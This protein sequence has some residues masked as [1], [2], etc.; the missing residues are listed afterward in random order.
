MMDLQTIFGKEVRV[1]P[2]RQRMIQD[3]SLGGYSPATMAT[4]VGVVRNL[5][6]FY[7]AAPDGLEEEQIRRYFL[8]L[9]QARKVSASTLTV[10]L[11]GIK[12]FYEKTLGREWRCFDLVRPAK[13]KKLPVVLAREEVWEI[14]SAVRRPVYRCCLTT[15][16][17]CGLRV[18]EGAHLAVSDIDSHRMLVHVRDGKGR[19]DRL[20]PLAQGTLE[21]L[22]ELWQSHRSRPWLFPSPASHPDRP[23]PV[24]RASLHN[25]FQAARSE[26]GVRKLASVH[27]LRHSY[28]THLLED[29]VS[30]RLIQAYL[31]H[32]SPRATA[33]YTHLTREVR[34]RAR[35]PIE[36]LIPRA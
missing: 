3:L 36:R 31:G 6:R 2:L 15:I 16:Y 13:P 29:G 26:S 35:E 23:R 19:K 17:G 22:R 33:L 1:T 21:R 11:C 4:Y 18:S 28:A 7:G 34:E 32:H 10:H 30:L 20:V 9:T 27:T 25:A 12:F 24:T 5:A 14:L 8:H